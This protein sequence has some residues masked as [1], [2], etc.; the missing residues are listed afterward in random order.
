VR[1]KGN[2]KSETFKAHRF[3][4][5]AGAIGTP[6][7]LLRSQL[8]GSSGQVGRNYMYHAG[9][10]LATV[11]KKPLDDTETFFRRVGFAD[12]YFGT[13]EFPHKLGYTQ[14]LPVPGYLTLRN[15]VSF[16]IPRP[17]A[18]FFLRRLILMSGV[19]ED[20]PQPQNK[21]LIGRNGNIVLSH[22]YHAYDIYR[23]RY[24]LKKL[25][26]IF[27]NSDSILRFGVTADKDYRHTA[28]QVG[29]TRFGTDSKTAVLDADCRLFGHDNVFIADGGFMPT[30]LGVSPALTIIANALRVASIIEKEV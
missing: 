28:H 23:S 24:Y 10:L 7:I 22:K 27:K 18:S 1:Y 17:I 26:D 6:I 8:E 15:K 19:V 13:T 25:K 30:S 14:T 20:L 2:G 29:T 3:V 9:A 5:A 11:F 4:I 21:V 16:P 12:L